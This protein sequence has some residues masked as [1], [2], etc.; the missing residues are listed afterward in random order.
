MIRRR[1]SAHLASVGVGVGI[2]CV[3]LLIATTTSGRASATTSNPAPASAASAKVTG[4]RLTVG[5]GTGNTRTYEANVFDTEGNKIVNADLDLGG[6]GADPDLRVPTTP[7]KETGNSGV[8]RATVRFPADG[9]WVLVVRVHEPSQLVDL[10]SEKIAGAGA[11]PTHA[12]ISAS[13]SRRAVAAADPTFYQ[14]YDPTNPTPGSLS[15][16]EIAQATAT[17]HG[18]SQALAAES[19]STSGF[20]VSVALIALLHTIGAAAWVT[21]VLGL[22][23]ANRIDNPIAR[24][25]VTRFIS[26]HYLL[27]AMGGLGLV[28]ITGVQTALT[29]SAGLRDPRELLQTGLGTAYLA[30]FSFKMVAV[31]G[32]MLTSYRIKR[33]LPSRPQFAAQLQLASVGAKANDDLSSHA[34]TSKIYGLAETNAVLAASIIGCVVLLGQLHH[35]LL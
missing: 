17:G 34:N 13:P 19:G 27:L 12:D 31:C 15:E 3:A 30:V 23:L 14:R 6:L 28:T 1:H 20:D 16:R 7:M 21:S 8:Y 35:A 5:T 26:S 10:F 4:V 29:S 22:M 32:S 25:E 9:D 18:H 11:A 33:L 24:R 2:S